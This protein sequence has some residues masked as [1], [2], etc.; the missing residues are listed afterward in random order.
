MQDRREHQHREDHKRRGDDRRSQT[1]PVEVEKREGV[2][3][4]DIDRRESTNSPASDA[5]ES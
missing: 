4:S 5:D 3:R 1:L 2:R